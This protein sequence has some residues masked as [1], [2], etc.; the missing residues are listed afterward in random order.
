MSPPGTSAPIPPI[1]Q[2]ATQAPGAGETPVQVDGGLHFALVVRPNLA[3]PQYQAATYERVT[4]LR[5]FLNRPANRAQLNSESLVRAHALYQQVD[6][7]PAQFQGPPTP[8]QREIIASAFRSNDSTFMHGGPLYARIRGCYGLNAR[9]EP[10][11]GKPIAFFLQA[12]HTAQVDAPAG[13]DPLHTMIRLSSEHAQASGGAANIASIAIF[14][15]GVPSGIELPHSGEASFA[16][17]L[18]GHVRPRLDI[19]LY[20]CLTARGGPSSYAGQLAESV[21]PHC[22][23][24]MRVFGHLSAAPYGINSA[25]YEFLSEN[26]AAVQGRTNREVCLPETLLLAPAEVT[27]I[28]TAVGQPEE[29]VRAH[30]V[31]AADSWML[32]PGSRLSVRGPVSYTIG[33]RRQEV[34][35]AVQQAWALPNGGERAF[36][37]ALERHPAW[38]R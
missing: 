24:W 35:A 13:G 8:E 14:M 25:G 21:R 16:R 22:A 1:P 36:R 11:F 23:E 17:L 6:A 19:L 15:H 2:E 27:R 28:A 29:L 26:G 32:G 7:Q 10:T 9:G 37:T 34:I 31:E 3:L 4:N 20:C 33:F 38:R 30:L 12:N 5:E 18:A